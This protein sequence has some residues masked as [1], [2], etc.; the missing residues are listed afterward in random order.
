MELQR[1]L[2]MHQLSATQRQL[3]LVI[4]QVF[5]LASNSRVRIRPECKVMIEAL[6]IVKVQ[7]NLL[8]SLAGT[9]E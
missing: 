8:N 4:S 3:I 9:A 5:L 1:P 6:E 2:V 7:L